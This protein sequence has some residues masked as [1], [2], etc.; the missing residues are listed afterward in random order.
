MKQ[1]SPPKP[2]SW[3]RNLVFFWALLG[4][5]SQANAET[6]PC[7]DYTFTYSISSPNNCNA[8]NGEINITAVSG[9]PTRA[10]TDFTYSWQTIAGQS[11][12]RDRKS[13]V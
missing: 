12:P 13:V 7:G 8:S 11:A 2:K 1:I 4:I 3:F 9:S 6:F 10:L 5:V